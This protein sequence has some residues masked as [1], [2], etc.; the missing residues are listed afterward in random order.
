MSKFTNNTLYGAKN[1]GADQNVRMRKLVCA[2]AVHMQQACFLA[3]RLIF[4]W[5]KQT[6]CTLNWFKH[7]LLV[8]FVHRTND[9][10]TFSL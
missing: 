10:N 6:V 4:S 8:Y 7:G 3:P 1:K 9:I 2:F 5:P